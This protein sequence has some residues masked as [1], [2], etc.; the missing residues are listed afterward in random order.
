MNMSV[1]VVD[2]DSELPT[3]FKEIC[4]MIRFIKTFE[5]YSYSSV[6]STTHT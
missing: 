3:C 5:A 6:A 2:F 1:D 4:M